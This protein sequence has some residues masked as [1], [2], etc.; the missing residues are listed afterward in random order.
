M[1]KKLIFSIIFGTF[2]NT[3]TS[4]EEQR[5]LFDQRKNEEKLLVEQERQQLQQAKLKVLQ[6]QQQQ[7]LTNEKN[8]RGWMSHIQ[9]PTFKIQIPAEDEK[10]PIVIWMKD[11]YIG[12]SSFFKKLGGRYSQKENGIVLPSTETNKKIMYHLMD[13]DIQDSLGGK[14]NLSIF[15]SYLMRL[16]P[17]PFGLVFIHKKE[18]QSTEHAQNIYNKIANAFGVS[19]IVLKNTAKDYTLFIPAERKIPRQEYEQIA[20]TINDGIRDVDTEEVTVPPLGLQERKEFYAAQDRKRQQLEYKKR[21][22]ELFEQELQIKKEYAESLKQIRQ[23]QQEYQ[24]WLKNV[25]VPEFNPPK[26]NWDLPKREPYVVP[27]FTK[28][29]RPRDPKI[30]EENRKTVEKWEEENKQRKERMEA[31]EKEF[32]EKIAYKK[33]E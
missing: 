18:T 32:N 13:A 15:D 12:S 19:P 8:D 23:Q 2:V 24:D 31:Q 17:Q 16:E 22:E 10:G 21:E 11:K 25:K 9:D 1:N 5:Q 29:M 3:A 4:T 28:E 6:A 27:D 30:D 20:N 33:K 7:Y 26:I 14:D